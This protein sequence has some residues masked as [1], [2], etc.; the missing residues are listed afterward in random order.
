[1]SIDGFAVIITFL[2]NVVAVTTVINSLRVGQC[3]IR[4]R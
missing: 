3:V 4:R 1:M 2:S